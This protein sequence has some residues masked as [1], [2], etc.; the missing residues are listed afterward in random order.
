[1]STTVASAGGNLMKNQTLLPH[2]LL[3]F[4]CKVAKHEAKLIWRIDM[5]FVEIF[6]CIWSRMIGLDET[7]LM[8]MRPMTITK[9]LTESTERSAMT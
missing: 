4:T 5:G 1:M 2:L 6:I 8:S 3:V 9:M 7:E